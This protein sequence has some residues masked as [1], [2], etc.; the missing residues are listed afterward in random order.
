[1]VIGKPDEQTQVKRNDPAHK[2]EDCVIGKP[3]KQLKDSS[4]LYL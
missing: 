4:G 3:N 1:M 2:D